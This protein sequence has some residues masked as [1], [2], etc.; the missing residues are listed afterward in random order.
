[1]LKRLTIL[2]LIVVGAVLSLSAEA[3]GVPT[4]EEEE[5]GHTAAKPHKSPFGL[6]VR[7]SNGYWVTVNSA[8][9]GRVG[10]EASGA[11][12]SITYSA[13]G[14][15]SETGIHAD[16]GKYGQIDMEWVPSG[17]VREIRT[18]CHYKGIKQRFYDT[19]SY[20]GTLRFKGGG[21]FT[22]VNLGRVPW[23]RSWYS[24]LGPCGYSLSTAEPGAGVVINA[25]R[26]GHISAPVHFTVYQPHR[27]AK[28]EYSA[29]SE[30]VKGG[31]KIDRSAYAEGGPHSLTLTAANGRTTATIRPQ[32]PFYGG[33]TF[34]R[35]RGAKGTF[36]GKLGAEFPDHTKVNL[37]GRGFEARLRLESINIHLG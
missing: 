15:V 3:S 10:V 36:T 29:R 32:A 22:S 4:P 37:A 7:A 34:G 20:V 17:R 16:L 33:A 30:T 12:G 9:G 25:G 28:V 11:D 24:G 23:R 27:G 1:M 6:S 13:P 19:G 35:V 8:K 31:I 18:K 2:A 21:G 14:V 5:V 26:R